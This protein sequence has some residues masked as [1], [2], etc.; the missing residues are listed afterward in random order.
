MNEILLSCVP[1]TCKRIYNLTYFLQLLKELDNYYLDA[2]L[3][4][5][6][7]VK[8]ILSSHAYY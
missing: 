4:N 5:P 6:T 2:R 1:N 7:F 8:M 3:I